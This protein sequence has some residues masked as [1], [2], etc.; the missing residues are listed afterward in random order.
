MLQLLK[1]RTYKNILF[2]GANDMSEIENYARI[3]KN[4]IFIEAIPDVFLKL[5]YNL[6]RVN[7]LYNTKFKAVNCLVSNEI[8]KEYTFNIFNNNGQSSSIYQPNNDV[9]EWPSVKR[10]NSIKLISR[11]NNKVVL[12][13]DDDVKLFSL[14]D[15]NESKRFLDC[16][17]EF[18]ISQSRIDCI[19]VSESISSSGVRSEL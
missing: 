4:G 16:L 12:Q 11:L 6:E 5:K 14:N 13:N 9:W 18:L 3:Y 1:P 19:I 15:E 17:N 7:K 8:G 2:I 10:I